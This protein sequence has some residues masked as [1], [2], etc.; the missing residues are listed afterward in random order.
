MNARPP[1]RLAGIRAGGL[2]RFAFP[3]GSIGQWHRK[4]MRGATERSLASQV[5]YRCGD[6]TG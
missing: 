5:A 6:S 2:T 3:S 1:P 4:R